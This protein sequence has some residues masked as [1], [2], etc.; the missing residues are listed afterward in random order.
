MQG[1][2]LKKAADK[3]KMRTFDTLIARYYPLRL[4]LRFLKSDAKA[5]LGGLPVFIRA[6]QHRAC[7][8]KRRYLAH[9][10]FRDIHCGLNA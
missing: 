7:A 5:F 9:W 10:I 8:L 4:Q 6:F 2:T 3:N 1:P